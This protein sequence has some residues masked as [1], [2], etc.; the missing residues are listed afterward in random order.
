MMGL[1]CQ[2]GCVWLG[3]GR[4]F[5]QFEAFALLALCVGIAMIPLMRGF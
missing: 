1:C 5:A 4:R 3:G 2:I